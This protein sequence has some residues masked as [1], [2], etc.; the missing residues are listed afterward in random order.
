MQGAAITTPERSIRRTMQLVG[1]LSKVQMKE[2]GWRQWHRV[3]RAGF[4]A[5]VL[6][7]GI[8]AVAFV[9]GVKSPVSGDPGRAA[10]FGE[11]AD[12][13]AQR[14][15]CRALAQ[16]LPEVHAHILAQLLR[17]VHAHPMHDFCDESLQK[18]RKVVTHLPNPILAQS[19]EAKAAV[20][21]VVREPKDSETNGDQPARGRE[22]ADPRTQPCRTLAELVPGVHAHIL[23]QLL[24]GVYAHTMRN[25]CIESLQ[26]MSKLDTSSIEAV[27]HPARG[28]LE[29]EKEAEIE[30]MREREREKE[31]ERERN[32]R[33]R[34]IEIERVRER[35]E[36]RQRTWER[37]RVRERERERERQRQGGI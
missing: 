3:V 4:A 27:G 28:R 31:R 5:A 36:E 18:L 6:S 14:T 21:K 11:A 23:A 15:P 33:E 30:L 12:P 17:G 8:V 2:A 29:R 1:P 22:K 16:L 19:A 24:R 13:L 7:V 32:L 20:P 34:K 35:E 25:F 26:Q 9:L 10:L 37:E